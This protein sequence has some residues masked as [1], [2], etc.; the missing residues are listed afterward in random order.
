MK[1][2]AQ[3]STWLM[4]VLYQIKFR[5]R[6]NKFRVFAVQVDLYMCYKY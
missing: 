2:S 5:I 3:M 6:E 1:K 4:L